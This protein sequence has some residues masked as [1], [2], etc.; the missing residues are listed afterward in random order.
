MIEWSPSLL[1]TTLKVN[2]LS[3]LIKRQTGRIYFFV[4]LNDPTICYL[5]ETHFRSKDTNKL[6]VK[7]EKDI[8]G[9]GI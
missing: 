3:S 2:G 7:A 5:Q 9:P 4:F 1:I 6:K 8:L